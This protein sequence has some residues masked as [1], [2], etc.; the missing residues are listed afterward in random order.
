MIAPQRKTAF[1]A[2]RAPKPTDIREE[3]PEPSPLTG[4]EKQ[5]PYPVDALPEVI[6]E[7]VGEVTDFV[8]CPTS[9]MA[10]SAIAAISTVVAGQVDVRRA[11]KLVGPV[12]LFL[13]AVADSGERKSTADSFFIKVIRDWETKEEEKFE[14][15][16]RAYRAASKAWE[17]K[18]AGIVNAIREA[19]KK[20]DG[21][22][23][24]ETQLADLE[25][26]KPEKPKVP[27]LLVGDATSEALVYRLEHDWPVG[28]MLSSEAGV[29]FGGHAM[30]RDSI[31]QNLATLNALWD[32]QPLYVDRRTTESF[33]VRS[34]RLSLG[35]AVQP[36][37]VRQFMD[38]SRGLA[39]GIGFMARFLVAWPEST[40]GQR[41]FREAPKHWPA[42]ARFH[43]RLEELLDLPVQ[44]DDS[45]RLVL[46]TLHLSKEAK[47]RWV[48]FY[49]D[50]EAE[51]SPYG[52]MADARDVASKAGD[53]AARLA[54]LFHVFK[55]GPSGKIGP[56]HI[57][58]AAKIVTWHLFE[59]RRFLKELSIPAEVNNA[60][61]LEV[62][63]LK[64][65]QEERITEVPVN[66]VI[67]FGPNGTR[68]K[69]DLD[70]AIDEL[71]AVGRIRR[72]TD[73]RKKAIQINPALMR[74]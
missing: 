72:K 51:L 19:S 74:G 53:N 57:Q 68:K 52:E 1:A 16:L 26:Q 25:T 58:A 21:T 35:L 37:T 61:L 64:L 42:L 54:A 23:Q 24:F 27:R 15:E 38:A 66:H 32:G 13:M 17:A 33:T 22:V 71:E 59:A 6:G 11:D 8:Q 2:A 63:L 29:V 65:C 36:E 60:I 46:E 3:W 12:S 39:R 69:K 73:G 31:M 50:V 67:K 49:D 5:E 14:P 44:F 40:Q 45:G 48:K 10:C 41:M 30:K 62:W 7:A 28:G 55:H 47:L 70:A 4:G 56:E 34:A 18:R 43:R 20:G 9:L